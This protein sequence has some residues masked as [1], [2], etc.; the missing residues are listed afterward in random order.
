MRGKVFCG[1]LW[2]DMFG[3]FSKEVG[4]SVVIELL[5]L[6]IVDGIRS[7]FFFNLSCR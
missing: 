4:L 6:H 3:I 7:I 1:D 2:V 5:K